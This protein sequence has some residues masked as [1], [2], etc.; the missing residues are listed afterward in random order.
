MGQSAAVAEGFISDNIAVQSRR[1]KRFCVTVL[2]FVGR[3]IAWTNRILQGN[4]IRKRT[5]VRR[6]QIRISIVGKQAMFE[7]SSVHR[8]IL[9]MLRPLVGNGRCIDR[10]QTV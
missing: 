8:G 2:F 7:S 1:A 3:Q 6:Q 10:H 4:V 9:W 5:V